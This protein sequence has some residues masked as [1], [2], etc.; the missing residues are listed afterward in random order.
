MRIAVIGVG[1]IGGFVAASLRRAG[2]DVAVVARGAHLAAIR[3]SGLRLITDHDDV[4]VRVDA[5]QDIREFGA[6]DIVFVATKA[7]QLLA[8]R[9]Q[10]AAIALMDAVLVPMQNGIPFWYDR[11]RPLE[12]VDPG[13]AVLH[14]VRYDHL[15]GSVV[16]ASGHVEAPG[17]VRAPGVPTYFFGELDGSMTQ[18][19][20][21][22]IDA[23]AAAGMGPVASPDI[24]RNVWIKVAGNAST[25][26]ISALTRATIG[27]IF[28]D[29]RVSRVVETLVAEVFSVAAAG[30]CDV[31]MTPAERVEHARRTVADVKT[32]MLQDVE[33]RRPL[34]LDPIVGAV[35]E[36]AQRHSL[37]VPTLGTI[38]ALT[39]ALERSYRS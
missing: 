18:R 19:L 39:K 29:E 8:L 9:D 23:C 1:G 4:T 22:L 17:V 35:I 36:L 25:N 28:A 34:E 38:Y 26:P 21:A 33:A 20:Q 31:G 3:N 2:Q 16:H 27:S 13:G 11:D 15:I 7:H 24:R 30:G 6:F 12:S 32:S 5:A 10:L 37:G 14:S